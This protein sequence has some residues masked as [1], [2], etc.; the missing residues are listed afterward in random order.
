MVKAALSDKDLCT[1]FYDHLIRR[2]RDTIVDDD[3]M[4]VADRDRS[5]VVTIRRKRGR[6]KQSGSH[7]INFQFATSSQAPVLD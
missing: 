1:G 3:R 6:L 5:A 2:S 4:S 7:I